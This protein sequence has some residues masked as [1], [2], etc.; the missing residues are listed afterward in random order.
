MVTAIATSIAMISND[1]L[2]NQTT[3]GA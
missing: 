1:W 3:P 2:G